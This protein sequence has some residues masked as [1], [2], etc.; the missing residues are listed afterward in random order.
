MS[1]DLEYNSEREIMAI[2]EYGRHVHKLIAHC[3]TLKTKE[4]RNELANAIIEVMGNMQPHLRDVEDFKHKLW[5]QL[6]IMADYDLDVDTPYEITPQDVLVQKPEKLPYPGSPSKYRYYGNNIQNLIR[7]AMTWDEGE[8]KDRLIRTIAE[9]MKKC[10]LLWNKDTV[11][12]H[13]IREHLKD[14][15]YGKLDIDVEKEPLSDSSKFLSLRK[16]NFKNNNKNKKKRK[17]K[18]Y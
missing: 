18:K 7:V 8:E 17:Y 3:K 11:N 15:S 4:E 13:I 5:D 10:Y 12:D 14:L 1:F 6:F 9:H 2:P 16:K